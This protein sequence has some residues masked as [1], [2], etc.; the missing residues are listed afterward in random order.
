MGLECGECERDLRGGHDLDCSRHPMSDFISEVP[1]PEPM[2]RF[3]VCETRTVLVHQWAETFVE[4]KSE[5]EAEDIV[6]KMCNEDRI[7][8][9]DDYDEDDPFSYETDIECLGTLDDIR[10]QEEIRIN[11]KLPFEELKNELG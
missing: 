8:W 4:A 1:K 9:N 7:N 5:S 2:K 6:R 3:K 10:R 11:P